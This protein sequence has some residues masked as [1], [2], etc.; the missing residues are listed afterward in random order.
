MAGFL[1]LN[2]SLCAL[3]LCAVIQLAFFAEVASWWIYWYNDARNLS[4]CWD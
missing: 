4:P 3:H 2:G 1:D